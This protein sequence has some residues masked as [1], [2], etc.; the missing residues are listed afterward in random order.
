M[1]LRI[2]PTHTGGGGNLACNFLFLA[3][4]LFLSR[5]FLSATRKEK[6]L[7]GREVESRS[8]G[9]T[10]AFE[11]PVHRVGPI[12]CSSG[13]E[14]LKIDF[15]LPENQF[16][17]D[18]QLPENQFSPIPWLVKANSPLPEEEKNDD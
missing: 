6:F 9:D 16:S 3:N 4:F 12:R 10:L 14:L 11:P 1:C 15:Q 18:F 13:L 5:V 7:D 8:G 2:D 17:I